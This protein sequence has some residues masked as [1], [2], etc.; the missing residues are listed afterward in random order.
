MSAYE[1]LLSL[2]GTSVDLIRDL[3]GCSE[4]VRLARNSAVESWGTNTN[5]L[6]IVTHGSLMLEAVLPDGQ[7]QV[8]GFRFPGDLL[9]TAFNRY[10]PMSNACTL[11]N[12]QL[13][14]VDHATIKDLVGKS[15]T[16]GHA[17]VSAAAMQMERSILHNLVLGR[18]NVHQR[19]ASFL[20]EMVLRCGNQ[21]VDRVTFP[22]PM[23]RDD[24]GDYLGLNADTVS[25]T[26]SQFRKKQVYGQT[27]QCE[28]YVGDVIRLEQETPLAKALNDRYGRK[29]RTDLGSLLATLDT[30][31]RPD[32]ASAFPFSLPQ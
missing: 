24:I 27:N 1:S 25:R 30:N 4:P 26:L 6:L 32:S 9:C 15:R 17:L 19:V 13:I 21:L 31:G 5:G 23:T 29:N 22:M 10:L 16:L 8:L 3:F 2:N 18:L 28:A 14:R 11:T 12:V 7:R 20:L